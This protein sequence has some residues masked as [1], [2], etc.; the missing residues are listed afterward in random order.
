[1]AHDHSRMLGRLRTDY[2]PSLL[3]VPRKGRIR[4]ALALLAIAGV[5]WGFSHRSRD[6]APAARMTMP[7]RKPPPAVKISPAHKPLFSFG[8]AAR[9]WDAGDVAALLHARPPRLTSERD[10]VSYAG[11]CI[12]RYSLDTALQNLSLRLMEQYQPRYGAAVVIE[13]SSG[14]ILALVS[15]SNPHA[16][17]VPELWGRSMFPA[18]SVFK[19]ITAAA[20]I[21]NGRLTTES[22]LDLAGRRHTLY[23]FQIK[24][25]LPSADD[26][27]LKEAYAQSVNPVFARIGMYM[28]GYDEL[29]SCARKWGFL[30]PVP[31]ELPVDTSAVMACD[32][33]FQIAEMAS[34][35]NKQTTLSPLH[36]ALIVAAVAEDG[37]M[38]RPSLVDSVTDAKTGRRLYRMMPTLWR[39]PIKE[40]TAAQIRR[41]MAEVVRSGT[42]R[43]SF[44]YMRNTSRF[45]DLQY[46]GK[47][48]SIDKDSL[49]R[50]DWFVGFVR[51]PADP[52]QE[53]AAGV[54][55][56][57]GE[58]WTVHSSYI[59]EELMRHHIRAVQTGR[60]GADTEVVKMDSVGPEEPGGGG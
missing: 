8:F 31:F 11:G 48:G 54:V 40:S 55:T 38:P 4:A 15:Y 37:R 43:Q 2:R 19:T 56:V 57:H 46:G 12:V 16:P 42:A 26:I 6:A 60:K 53:L 29:I 7:A 1:M 30:G 21:D 27:T 10:T 44:R 20:A 34:G 3:R 52:R 51:N 50:I 39:I 18:A 17:M 24:E 45:E 58:Y 59:V 28:V 13:P 33:A 36:G 14:R 47:T 22:C 23:R 5:V 41:M 49:G 9:Q 35:F 25:N 32:S